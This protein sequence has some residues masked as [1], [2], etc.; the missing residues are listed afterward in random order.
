MGLCGGMPEEM[1]T[2]LKGKTIAPQIR[3]LSPRGYELYH[4]FWSI[5]PDSSAIRASYSQPP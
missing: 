5:T 3:N 2:G 1:T 4:R